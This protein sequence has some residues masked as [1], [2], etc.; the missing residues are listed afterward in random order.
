[1]LLSQWSYFD[2]A[3]VLLEGTSQTIYSCMVWSRVSFTRYETDQ[4]Y[5]RRHNGNISS[6]ISALF[7]LFCVFMC[8]SRNTAWTFV[9]SEPLYCRFPVQSQ[10]R[11][12]NESTRLREVFHLMESLSSSMF[13]PRK[14]IYNQTSDISQLATAHFA[15]EKSVRFCLVK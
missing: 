4:L 15:A 2:I 7:K 3:L 12:L 14:T 5:S 1:M 6:S 9:V 8:E 13:V 10:Y 11:T